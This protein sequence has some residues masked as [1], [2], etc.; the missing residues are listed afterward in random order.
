MALSLSNLTGCLT[1]K[2]NNTNT[3]KNQSSGIENQ[4]TVKTKLERQFARMKFK[5]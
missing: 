3:C 2:N 5:D 4:A 1:W